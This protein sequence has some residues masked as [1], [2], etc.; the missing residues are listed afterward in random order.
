VT[1]V[2]SHSALDRFFKLG[3]GLTAWGIF[4]WMLLS[5]A[6]FL[7]GI[8]ILFGFSLLLTYILLAPVNS[9]E[10]VLKQV[11]YTVL[12]ALRINYLLA[13]LPKMLPRAMAILMVYLAFGLS[14]LV[15]SVRFLPIAV[16]QLHEFTKEMPHYIEQS[17]EWLLNQPVAMNYF[18]QEVTALQSRGELTKPQ[19]EVIEK[20]AQKQK[21]ALVKAKPLSPMEK[22]VI[23]EKLFVTPGHVNQFMKDHIASAFSNLLPLIGS[24]LTGFVYA[25]T[26]LVLVFYFLLDGKELKDKF[27]HMLPRE[28]HHSADYLL[29]SMHEVM[30]GFVKGQVIL[31]AATGIYMIIVYTFFDV[32][33]AF[34]LGA[35]FAVAE[36]LPVV[37]TWLGFIPG[38]IV[39]LFTNPIKLVM[40][41]GL[42]Y[43]YQL[44]KDNMVAPRV[45]GKVMG[46]HPVIVIL[47][48]LV[49]A[50]IAGLVGVLFAIPLASMMN[51]LFR[52]FQQEELREYAP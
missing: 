46:L 15:V 48:L 16:E 3:V 20:E 42:V 38:I 51:V 6:N 18:H 7:I 31:G 50:K 23:R 45:I 28:N 26:G 44:I 35:F 52:Y 36:I 1:F 22:Q 49:C 32:P 33:Y 27:I 39:L 40:V 14:V 30:F 17:E 47:S 34:F 19:R 25:I 43:I 21:T 24:T 4:I 37:G 29:S 41:M 8:V 9:M 13:K 10:L 12:H 2:P 5:M 11:L